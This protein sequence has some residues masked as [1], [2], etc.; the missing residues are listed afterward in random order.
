MRILHTAAID[1][2]ENVSESGIVDFLTMPHGLF[3]TPITQ[4]SQPPQAQLFWDRMCIL[5]CPSKPTQIKFGDISH[6]KWIATLSM[7]TKLGLQDW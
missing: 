6:A 1:M 5:M 2:S 7:K 4:C 3:V